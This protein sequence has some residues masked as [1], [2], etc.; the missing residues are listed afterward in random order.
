MLSSAWT[1][2]DL[3]FVHYSDIYTRDHEYEEGTAYWTQKLILGF[4]QGRQKGNENRG[5]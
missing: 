3:E 4:I 1:I 2:T 5:G